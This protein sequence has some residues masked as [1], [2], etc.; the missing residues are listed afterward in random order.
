MSL[1]KKIWHRLPHSFQSL[2]IVFGETGTVAFPSWGWFC[3]SM[4]GH[5]SGTKG[6]LGM[7]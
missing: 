7:R 1:P 6:G 3:G 4:E 5:E 2:D